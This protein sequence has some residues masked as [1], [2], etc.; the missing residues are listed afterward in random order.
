V[1]GL[2]Y[3]PNQLFRM[4][5]E[6]LNLEYLDL[7]RATNIGHLVKEFPITVQNLKF[8]FAE[9]SLKDFE[10][11]LKR[12]GQSLRELHFKTHLQSVGYM[13]LISQY[14]PNLEILCTSIHIL[15]YYQLTSLLSLCPKLKIIKTELPLPKD[16]F[17]LLSFRNISYTSRIN[18]DIQ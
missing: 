17:T 2:Y 16:S 18:Y 13:D 14:C 6:L 11:I 4:V 8:S 15:P 12:C 1:S 7:R 9:I 5:Y 3:L 10:E